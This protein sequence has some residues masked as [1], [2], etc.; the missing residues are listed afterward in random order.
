M[1]DRKISREPSASASLVLGL[2]LVASFV[3]AGC[4]GFWGGAEPFLLGGIQVNEEDPEF[5]AQ[6]LKR[7]GM[8]TVSVTVYAHQGTWDSDDLWFDAQD[9]ALLQEIRAAKKQG[10]EVVLILRVALNHASEA[11]QFLWHGMIYPRTEEQM[12]S[13]FRKYQ[14]FVLQWSAIAEQ[15]GVDLLGVASELNEL[16]STRFL[17]ILPDLHEYYLNEEKQAA[18]HERILAHREDLEGRD[19]GTFESP[20]FDSL[21][22]FL[23][24]RSAAQRAWALAVTGAVVTGTASL[25][26]MNRRRALVEQEWRALIREVRKVYGGRLTYAANHDQYVEVQFWEDLDVL[27][28]N[29]YFPLREGLLREA[30]VKEALAPTA[31]LEETLEAGWSEV[32]EEIAAFRDESEIES[33]PVVFT[34]LGY[35]FRRGCTFEPWVS[36]GF[37]V[38]GP[39][40]EGETQLVIWQDQPEDPEERVLAMRGLRRAAEEVAPGMLRGLLYW[41]FS[42]KPSHREVEPFVVILG[43]SP[44]DPVLAELRRL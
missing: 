2:A 14:E 32:L 27:G 34:E 41:K 20:N 38:L 9:E 15:E 33:M 17:E 26:S 30:P 4:A 21:E 23:Q 1:N 29:A 19:L 3:F 35:T 36:L 11:N 13:W 25:D 12:R 44:E 24:A 40:D 28:I 37:S 5:W 8:N 39:R 22:A 42:T 6:S 43:E 10:L 31:A 7:E 18:E 16:T